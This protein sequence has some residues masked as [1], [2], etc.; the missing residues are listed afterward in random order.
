MYSRTTGLNLLA[1]LPPLQSQHLTRTEAKY[2]P[3][4]PRGDTTAHRIEQA[5]IRVMTEMI[6]PIRTHRT[7]YRPRAPA[8]LKFRRRPSRIDIPGRSPRPRSPSKN[9]PFSV[10][11]SKSGSLF[12][13]SLE[14]AILTKRA[15]WLE[16]NKLGRAELLDPIEKQLE[17]LE[18]QGLTV[19][20]VTFRRWR[21]RMYCD[22]E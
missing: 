22:A 19:D 5:R 9:S 11:N 17:N 14:T 10:R 7:L 16:A 20:A 18:R 2:S 3:T 4:S 12:E 6:M 13:T 1:M 8:S 21:E 15:K